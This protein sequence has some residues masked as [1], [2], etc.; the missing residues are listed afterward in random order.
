MI[1][2]SYLN[3]GLSED[4]T[5]RP[6]ARAIWYKIPAGCCRN[7]G[8]TENV[9]LTMAALGASGLGS[10]VSASLSDNCLCSAGRG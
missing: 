4:F 8:V 7:A 2:N 3:D 5:E 9:T 6:K 10:C 1:E